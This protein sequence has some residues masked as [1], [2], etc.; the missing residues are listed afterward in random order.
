MA[1]P[2]EGR[3]HY[4]FYA[5]QMSCEQLTLELVGGQLQNNWGSSG[6]LLLEEDRLLDGCFR[7]PIILGKRL[8]AFTGVVTL[9]EDLRRN[10]SAG[11]N[12]P[13]ERHH[14]TDRY[15]SVGRAKSQDW[16]QHLRAARAVLH[17]LERFAKQPSNRELSAASYV[18]QMAEVFHE[19]V[20]TVAL[21]PLCGERVWNPEETMIRATT[22]NSPPHRQSR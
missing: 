17:A 4:S 21:K 18:D 10:A 20:N 14:R 7:L 13:T 2:F 22:L 19:E 12:R 16:I 3:R 6:G 8:E 15:R 1:P 11:E 5:W 9:G